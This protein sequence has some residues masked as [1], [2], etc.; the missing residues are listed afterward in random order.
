MSKKVYRPSFSIEE[1]NEAVATLRS[2]NS[3]NATIKMVLAKLA[4][5]AVR[6]ETGINKPSYENAVKGVTLSDLGVPESIGELS[7]KDKRTFAYNKMVS[8]GRENCTPDEI[9]LADTHA[10]ESGYMSE[11]DMIEFQEK[12]MGL[13]DI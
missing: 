5:Y 2:L 6:V 9:M 8:K 7:L 1:I 10:F 12:L 11:T 3:T 4:V 13:G